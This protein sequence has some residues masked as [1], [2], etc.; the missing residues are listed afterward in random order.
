MVKKLY[1]LINHDPPSLLMLVE[2]SIEGTIE[3]RSE[4]KNDRG[5]KEREEGEVHEYKK[6]KPR[7]KKVQ[8]YIRENF[9]AWKGTSPLWMDICIDTQHG[10]DFIRDGRLFRILSPLCPMNI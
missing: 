2:F 1:P 8:W 10:L 7:L 4:E 3:R 5:E 9:E 6:E